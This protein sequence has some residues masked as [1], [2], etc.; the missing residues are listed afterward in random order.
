M[1]GARSIQSAV[2]GLCLSAVLWSASPAVAD[3]MLAAMKIS[4][5]APDTTA[6]AFNLTSLD[7]TSIQLA[8]MKGKVVLD[9][10]WATWCG[11]CKN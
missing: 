3:D 2:Q 4:R 9:N 5:V 8:D 11:P 6:A 1:W 7:G 10:F